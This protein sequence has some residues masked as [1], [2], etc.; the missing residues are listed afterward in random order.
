MQSRNC[1]I[2]LIFTLLLPASAL[3]TE[4]KGAESWG[5]VKKT[6]ANKVYFDTKKTFYCG[7]DLTFKSNG[8]GN[9]EADACGLPKTLKWVNLRNKIQ[10]E[11]IVPGSLM[12]IRKSACWEKPSSV[13]AC[14]SPNGTVKAGR[15]CCE[16]HSSEGQKMLFDLYNVVPAAAQLNQYRS[17][18]VYGVVPKDAA[19]E[20]FG[21]QCAAKD[22]NSGSL[23]EP[24]DCKKG[25]VARVWFYM[26][27]THGVVIPNE[28]SLMFM[29]WSD[30]DPV[31]PSEHVSSERI[32]KIQGSINSYVIG[33]K[34]AK[35]GSCSWEE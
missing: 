24:P 10:W 9:I 18:D 20:G 12:P 16:E 25:D 14:V 15:K 3:A 5:N 11:H 34:T 29:R 17:D 7:C 32:S 31:S 8:A 30:A 33:K 1:S 4:F 2:L 21:E 22:L 27:D 19:Y 23:F 26:R 35:K 6:L 28:M 13:P